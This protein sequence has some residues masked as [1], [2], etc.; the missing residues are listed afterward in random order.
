VNETGRGV[1]PARVG[2]EAP[3]APSAS[4]VMGMDVGAGACL[5][6]RV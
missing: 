6:R 1:D 5:T 3:F 4:A 2:S